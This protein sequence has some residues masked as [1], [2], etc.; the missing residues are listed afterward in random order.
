MAETDSKAAG[1]V[2]GI[3]IEHDGLRKHEYGILKNASFA[4]REDATQEGR[5]EMDKRLGADIQKSI[6]EW[7]PLIDFDK[8]IRDAFNG[9]I[10]KDGP[11][12]S[13]NYVHDGDTATLCRYQTFS[14]QSADPAKIVKRFQGLAQSIRE[15]GQSIVWRRHPTLLS[16]FRMPEELKEITPEEAA[17]YYARCRLH[18]V[19]YVELPGA[20][21]EG[22][23]RPE[24]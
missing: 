3:V 5:D 21:L 23:P 2:F 14:W 6:T 13:Y 17:K 15:S 1:L 9:I 11:P 16:N 22:E 20:K 10:Q 18:V 4:G 7:L 12:D 19:P 24:A 8:Q